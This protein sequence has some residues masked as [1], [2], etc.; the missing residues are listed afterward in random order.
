MKKSLVALAVAVCLP[1]FA[2]YFEPQ[3]FGYSM[4]TFVVVMTLVGAFV[5]WRLM[6]QASL[7]PT[8][9]RPKTKDIDPL[10]MRGLV[11]PLRHLTEH[12]WF[13]TRHTPHRLMKLAI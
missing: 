11:E 6:W 8:P 12:P 3:L 5:A 10:F 4:L 1:P 7:L 13:L 2:D 9:W